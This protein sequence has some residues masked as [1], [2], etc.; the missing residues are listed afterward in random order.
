MKL[1]RHD[2]HGLMNVY[3]PQEIEEAKKGGWVVIDRH[4]GVDKA[5]AAVVD[6]VPE[7]KAPRRGRTS[8][9]LQS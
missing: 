8:K 9:A 4:P 7:Q 2:R 6:D 5:L 1:M 3:S